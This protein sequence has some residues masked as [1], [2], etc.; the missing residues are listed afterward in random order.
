[1]IEYT[2]YIEDNI[3]Y[4]VGFL[5]YYFYAIIYILILVIIL[6]IFFIMYKKINFITKIFKKIL[7]LK[8][9]SNY[10]L[11]IIYNIYYVFYFAS[12]INFVDD[13][14]PQNK[15]STT[16]PPTLKMP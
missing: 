2:F 1:M 4:I 5:H 8:S 12:R 13:Y 15:F 10:I 7:N 11:L 3:I 9:K 16:I 14:P 6:T